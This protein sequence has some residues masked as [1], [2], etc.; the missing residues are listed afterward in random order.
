MQTTTGGAPLILNA[1][2]MTQ[3][4]KVIPDKNGKPLRTEVLVQRSPDLT[5]KYHYWHGSD[6]LDTPP[7]NHPW[8]FSSEILQGAY[9]EQIWWVENGEVKTETRTYN[10]GNVNTN[11]TDTYHLIVSVEPGTVSKMTCGQA[12]EGN[13]WGWLDIKTGE[14]MQATLDPDFLTKLKALNPWMS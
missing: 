14:H 8:N 4:P 9:T 6:P 3:C 12:S 2:M 1:P 10:A 11:T 7:H 5:I 13:S